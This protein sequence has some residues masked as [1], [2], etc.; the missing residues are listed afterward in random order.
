MDLLVRGGHQALHPWWETVDA[1]V[2]DRLPRRGRW[3]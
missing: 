3:P 1:A 2:I